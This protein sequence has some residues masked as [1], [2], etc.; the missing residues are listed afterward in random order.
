MTTKRNTTMPKSNGNNAM[1]VVESA[2]VPSE[3]VAIVPSETV[4]IVPSELI[5][6]RIVISDILDLFIDINESKFMSIDE[7]AMRLKYQGESMMIDLKFTLDSCDVL[8]KTQSGK[9]GLSLNWLERGKHN[10]VIEFRPNTTIQN[11][12]YNINLAQK[13]STHMLRVMGGTLLK[14]KNEGMYSALQANLNFK[15][16]LDLHMHMSVSYANR[17]IK[18]YIFLQKIEDYIAINQLPETPAQI[19]ALMGL[20]FDEAANIWNLAYSKLK[21][22]P[23]ASE[24]TQIKR[25]VLGVTESESDNDMVD[26]TEEVKAEE[27]KAEEVKAE[28]V[29]AEEVKAEEVKAEEVKA[30]EVEVEEVE[31]EEVKSHASEVELKRM[32]LINQVIARLD[33]ILL[34]FPMLAYRSQNLGSKDSKIILDFNFN[35]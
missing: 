24:L 25:A 5:D 9:Y 23:K 27:V 2:I 11:C 19:R 7:I 3:T 6:S 26:S 33:P 30:E 28:E 18:C 14:V 16:W 21:R 35:E 32:E 17:L 1:P 31:A 12:M 15:Q 20:D 29:K 10:R 22:Q 34:D 13:T 8:T 4:A